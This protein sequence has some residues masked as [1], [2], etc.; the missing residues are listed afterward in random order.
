MLICVTLGII[1][2][3]YLCAILR[4]RAKVDTRPS[5]RSFQKLLVVR[6]CVGERIVETTAI[7]LRGVMMLGARGST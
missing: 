7:P 6:R 2:R 5:L 3:D 1:L 4:V